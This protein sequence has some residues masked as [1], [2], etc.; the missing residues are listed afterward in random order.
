MN[1]PF[2]LVQKIIRKYGTRI[3]YLMGLLY[4]E[5]LSNKFAKEHNQSSMNVA[6]TEFEYLY[7]TDDREKPDIQESEIKAIDLVKQFSVKNNNPVMT[8]DYEK[9]MEKSEDR[10]AIAGSGDDNE[11]PFEH[12]SRRNRITNNSSEIINNGESNSRNKKD[13][14]GTQDHKSSDNSNHNSSIP[15]LMK[16]LEFYQK[17]GLLL[18]DTSS[19][20]RELVDR[21]NLKAL[22]VGNL[23]LLGS[24]YTN[25]ENIKTQEIL[26]HEMRHVEQFI[27]SDDE[28]YSNPVKIDEL[29]HEASMSQNELLSP[30]NRITESSSANIERA[31]F[32]KG[33]EPEMVF[34]KGKLFTKNNNNN[35]EDFLIKESYKIQKAIK[36]PVNIYNNEYNQ[37]FEHRQTNAISSISSALPKSTNIKNINTTSA[38]YPKAVALPAMAASEDPTAPVAK[39]KTSSQVTL[40]EQS[41]EI[42]TEEVIQRINERL[43]I[44]RERFMK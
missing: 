7:K 36:N 22:T 31:L 1:Y 18:I 41:I 37:S 42:I 35:S 2:L 15:S 30:T 23:I 6:D 34:V 39:E 14:I 27:A 10:Y 44:E 21:N 38:G 19:S 29:E 26:A 17:A 4:R 3:P 24:N 11:Q 20:A 25:F 5:Y 13:S 8:S 32:N 43:I 9:N 12:I 28:T 33:I 16:K 40:S